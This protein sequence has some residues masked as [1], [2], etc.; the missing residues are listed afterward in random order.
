MVKVHAQDVTLGNTYGNLIAVRSGVTV[1]ERVVT[2]GTNTI[3]NG[4]Q[5]R[6]IP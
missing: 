5:V 6:I 2:S 4:D 1:G 3:K